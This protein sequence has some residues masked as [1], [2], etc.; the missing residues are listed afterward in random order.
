VVQRSSRERPLLLRGAGSERGCGAERVGATLG[1]LGAE[2]VST[3]GAG[4][5]LRGGCQ[6]GALAR[7]DGFW[8]FCDTPGEL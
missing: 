1:W 3:D 8:K 2:R 7:G 4:V 5:E 6:A